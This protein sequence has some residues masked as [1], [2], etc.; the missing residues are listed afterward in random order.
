LVQP[1]F[2]D[3]RA[4]VNSREIRKHTSA[5]FK[6]DEKFHSSR[7]QLCRSSKYVPELLGI[8]NKARSWIELHTLHYTI[9]GQHLITVSSVKECD[10]AMA[11]YS[12]QMKDI[13]LEINDQV[14]KDILD[15]DVLA[16]TSLYDR[17]NYPDNAQAL[18]DKF[19]MVWKY[20][21]LPKYGDDL[22]DVPKALKDRIIADHASDNHTLQHQV[23]TDVYQRAHK[24][25]LKLR[26][27]TQVAGTRLYDSVVDN[28]A[29]LVSVID[30]LNVTNDQNITAIGNEIR[31]KLTV[32]T[33]DQIKSNETARSD[34][35]KQAEDI[36]KRIS[37]L[38]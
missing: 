37:G 14:F 24:L 11:G 6:V 35:N 28:L 25:V 9:K 19:G 3:W 34:V 4:V 1:R 16:L 30:D 29:E 32:C 17:K 13:C 36:L 21:P 33:A 5:H 8:V 18:T 2:S 7:V 22:D 23:K 12:S 26:D 20:L 31:K 10:L 27:N 15:A 38:M